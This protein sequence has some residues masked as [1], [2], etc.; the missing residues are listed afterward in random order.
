MS[1][2]VRKPVFGVTEQVPHKPGCTTTDDD[3]YQTCSVTPQ[4]GFFD[5]ACV[6]KLAMFLFQNEESPYKMI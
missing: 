4:T 1:H 3:L 2:I 5:A 6:L